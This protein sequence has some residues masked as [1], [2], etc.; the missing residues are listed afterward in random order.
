MKGVL[1]S[2]D[3][4]NH[5]DQTHEAL[6]ASD[7]FDVTAGTDASLVSLELSVKPSIIPPPPINKLLKGNTTNQMESLFRDLKAEL[8]KGY[9][10]AFPLLRYLTLFNRNGIVCGLHFTKRLLIDDHLMPLLEKIAMRACVR[11]WLLMG[12]VIVPFLGTIDWHINGKTQIKCARFSRKR[13]QF[14]SYLLQ[15]SISFPAIT[16]STCRHQILPTVLAAF[17]QWDNVI[18]CQILPS[19]A[20][21][22]GTPV[23]L[24]HI[25]SSEWNLS[26]FEAFHQL[27]ASRENRYFP[28]SLPVPNL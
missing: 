3:I 10:F 17:G 16:F 23:P 8:N 13:L 20:V 1:F 14:P 7:A 21:D 5:V 9:T 12:N 19:A 6:D 18:Q 24:Q 2:I 28:L 4:R 11:L 26:L 25:S 15:R 22:T 27:A